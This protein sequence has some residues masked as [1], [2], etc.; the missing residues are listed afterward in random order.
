MK[1]HCGE[2][3]E[4]WDN[5]MPQFLG[6]LQSVDQHSF[7][8]C[9]GSIVLALSPRMGHIQQLIPISGHSITLGCPICQ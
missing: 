3:F 7:R 6:F 2:S 1:D 9:W 5:S 8:E 4:C